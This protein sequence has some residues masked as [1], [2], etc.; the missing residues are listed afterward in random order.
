MGKRS[1][2]IEYFIARGKEQF[3]HRTQDLT[4]NIDRAAIVQ[5]LWLQSVEEGARLDILEIN[6]IISKVHAFSNQVCVG[7]GMTVKELRE[8]IALLP[9]NMPI[10]YERIEDKYFNEN[11]WSAKKIISEVIKINEKDLEYYKENPN[12]NIEVFEKDGH[13]FANQYSS[14]I[15]AST[16]YATKDKDG[17]KIFIITAHY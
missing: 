17:Q 10:F 9:D 7:F 11:N 1:Q 5:W 16:G 8:K 2:V 4:F 12:E 15:D 3:A 14:Y 6:E 13:F